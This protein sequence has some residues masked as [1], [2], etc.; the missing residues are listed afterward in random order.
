MEWCR[1]YIPQKLRFM[2]ALVTLYPAIIMILFFGT[3]RCFVLAVCDII[4]DGFNGD[5]RNRNFEDYVIDRMM[6]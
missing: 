5:M 4:V 2:I 1:R 3:F 6:K